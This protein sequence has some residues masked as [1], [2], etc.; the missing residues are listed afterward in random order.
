MMGS[1]PYSSAV[2]PHMEPKCGIWFGKL[3]TEW[4]ETPQL[5]NTCKY[6][7]KELM[8][9]MYPASRAKAEENNDVSRGGDNNVGL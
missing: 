1:L 4:W 7:E 2:S 3:S 5:A 6:G 9:D 8:K